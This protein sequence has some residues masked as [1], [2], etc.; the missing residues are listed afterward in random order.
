MFTLC[1]Q[2]LLLKSGMNYSKFKQKLKPDIIFFTIGFLVF[3][4]IIFISIYSIFRV[5]DDTQIAVSF[6]IDD[7]SVSIQEVP[8]S[9]SVDTNDNS[10][11]N[12]GPMTSSI[13]TVRTGHTQEGYKKSLENQEYISNSGSWNATQYSEGDIVENTYVVQLGDTL[14]QIANAY[15]GSGDQWLK[16]LEVNKDSIGTL[17][18]GEQALIVPGQL[19]KLP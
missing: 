1:I 10:E 6:P 14:W 9:P 12:P 19:L 8:Q 17:P 15:Y 2:N 3:P 13:S 5:K 4:I 18:D 16:I 11:N 7:I